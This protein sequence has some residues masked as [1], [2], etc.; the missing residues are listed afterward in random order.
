MDE[1]KLYLRYIWVHFVGN[2]YYQIR[3]M[4][5]ANPKMHNTRSLYFPDRITQ[6]MG[7]ILDYPLTVVEAPMGYGKTTAVRESI[8]NA[9]V[10]TK[11]QRVH[12]GSIHSFWAGF[13]NMFSELNAES[14]YSLAQLGFPNDSVL[15]QEAVS[16]IE[17]IDFPNST[18]I[19]IDDYQTCEHVQ[20]DEFIKYLIE[21][22]IPNLKIVLIVRFIN[23]QALEELKLKGYIKHISKET[24]EFNVKEIKTYYR[25]CGINLKDAQADKLYELTEG[26]ISAIYL[27]LLNYLEDGSFTSTA[28]IYKL[29]EN[30]LYSSFSQEVKEFLQAICL[31]DYFTLEQAIHMWQKEDTDKLL[32]EITNKNAL[33]RYDE[34]TR[35]YQIHSIFTKLLREKFENSKELDKKNIYQKIAHWYLKTEDYFS[36]MNYFYIAEDFDML[37]NVVEIDKGNCIYSERKDKFIQFFEECLN[38]IRKEHPIA[39]LI[40]AI[41]LFMLNEFE[42]FEKACNEFAW[43]VESSESLDDHSRSVLLGEFQILLCIAE[44]NDIAKMLERIEQA[45]I[46][47]EEPARFIDTQFGWTFGSPSVL[48]MFYREAG[49]LKLEVENIKEALPHYSR[50]T[51]GHG[52]GGEFVMEAEW[53][54]N[55]GD[56]ENAEIVAHKAYYE[57]AQYGQYEII[58]CSQFLQ[59]RIALLK[60]DYFYAF[61]ALNKLHDEIKLRKQYDFLH[62]IDLCDAFMHALLEKTSKIPNWIENG[63]FDSSRLY[64]PAKAFMNIV[65]G[66]VL[67][68]N[69]EYYKLLGIADQFMELAGVFPNVLGQIYTNIYVAAA[70]EKIFRREEAL[71]ALKCAMDIAIEDKVYIPFVENCDYIKPLLTLMLGEGLYIEGITKIL[72]LYKPY[73]ESIVH[74]NNELSD[75]NKPELT[76]R[77]IEIANLAAKGLTNKEIGEKLF[78]TQNTVKTML[79]RVFEKLEINSRAMLRQYFDEK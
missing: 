33:I 53:Y 20:S 75:N 47:L 61:N 11:W 41:S 9:G 32:L 66:R 79:K 8:K 52:K 60:G 56:F 16:I 40:Y 17:N 73:E 5:M 29:L 43:V 28:N 21:Q 25:I 58:I 54:F 1:Y 76:E 30:T 36:A 26:W 3:G 24:F 22:E 46:L 71:M 42:R 19:V 48:Y 39:L 44:Y 13:C 7:E 65:Y 70:S 51:N 64:F 31:F 55:R 15:R 57:A 2:G 77:E 38:E 49:E 74:M 10:N 78:I 62:T 67:L 63:D 18:V 23:F 72:E 69:K 35:I 6:A 34:K 27:L 68:V 12:D 14:A 50:L 59:M 45:N 4:I 37:M